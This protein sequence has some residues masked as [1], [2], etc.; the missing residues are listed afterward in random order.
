MII[1]LLAKII[2]CSVRIHKKFVKSNNLLYLQLISRKNHANEFQIDFTKKTREIVLL[3][4]T[5]TS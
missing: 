4:L 1:K 2:D 3:E 5:I